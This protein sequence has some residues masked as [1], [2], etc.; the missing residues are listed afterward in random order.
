MVRNYFL[1]LFFVFNNLQLYAQ[2][3]TPIELRGTWITNVASDAMLTE[4]NVKEAVLNCKR[5]GLTDIFVVVWKRYIC[6]IFI[7]YQ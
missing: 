5:N 3:N 2:S 1:F 6:K 4:K 7:K